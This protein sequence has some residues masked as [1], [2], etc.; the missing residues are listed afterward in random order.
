MADDKLVRKTRRGSSESPDDVER[1]S[2]GVHASSPCGSSVLSDS[3]TACATKDFLMMAPEKKL[4]YF[5]SRAQACEDNQEFDACIRD[6]VRCVA[7]T[8]LVYGEDHLKLAQAHA[9]LAKAYFIF[10]GWGLQAQKHSALAR[11]LLPV[12]SSDSSCREDKMEFLVCLLS[13]HLTWAGA[14]L[15]TANLGEAESFFVEADHVVKQLHQHG[16]ISQEEKIKVELEICTGL[17]RVY[18]RQKRPE[19]ALRQCQKSLQLLRDCGQPDKMCSVFRDMATV[20]QSN[21]HLDQAI[22]HLTKAYD[23]VRSHSSNELEEAQIAHSLALN[24][25]ALAE[26]H[27]S[28]SAGHYFEQSLTAYKN[29]VGPQDP[30]FLTAQDDF[31]RYLLSNGQQKRCV[32]IQRSSLSDKRSTFGITSAEVAHTLLLIGSS[33][34]TEG[35]MKRAHRTLTKCLEIQ[36]LLYGGQH[37]KTKATQNAVDMLARAPEVAERRQSRDRR[38]ASQSTCLAVPS[39]GNDGNSEP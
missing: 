6:L 19:A 18:H 37:R 35:K 13:V 29:T 26:H 33:E 22:D 9:R 28:D 24:L 14:S 17:S 7:L 36:S 25:S 39:S 5:D 1:A 4:R 23:T 10:K 2:A 38:K 8:R 12:C 11:E 20:E 27:Q 34:M 32:E 21:G 16:G 31:C 30:A 3:Q 15:I